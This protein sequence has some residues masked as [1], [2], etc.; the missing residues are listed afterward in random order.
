VL[1]GLVVLPVGAGGETA[2]EARAAA[3]LHELWTASGTP[4]LSAAVASKGRI[5]FSQG[6]GFADLEHLVPAT[7]TTVYNVGSV[8]KVQTAV[9][10]MQLVEQGRVALQDPIRQYVPG[11]PD[12][13]APITLWH[14]M[15]HT[16]GIRHYRDTDFPGSPDNENTRPIA[17]FDDAIAIFKGDPLL[18]RP[19]AY[20]LYSSY[21][22]NLLQGV[23]EK[24]AGMP[25]EE[26][27]RRNV[28][29][30]A[31]MLSTAFDV[32]ERVVPHRARSYRF[33][34]GRA[35]N[36][37][38]NDLSYKFASGGMISTVEDLVR[39]GVA[40]DAGRLLKPETST[41]MYKPQLDPV[42]RYEEKGPP[43]RAP[44]RQ[45]LMWTLREDEA[46]R[47]FVYHCGSVKAFNA[48]LVNYPA[49]DLVAAIAT[50]SWQAGGFGPALA[51]ADLFRAPAG[52]P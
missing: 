1:L 48:C 17:S 11:F 26:Y 4:A 44:F 20:F 38:Y 15:T 25:F 34:Q 10:I 41:S 9:A 6:V 7:G 30:P 8:S 32:P 3:Q 23:V 12:K 40:L 2:P 28:W 31:G 43:T 37:Y 27:M 13:A 16:S 39:F 47:S 50:N 14:L 18:F 35:L 46:G 36:Y 42:M 21:A 22:V 5:V 29:G 52:R 24:A 19:G 33:E 51:L 49:E 45:G